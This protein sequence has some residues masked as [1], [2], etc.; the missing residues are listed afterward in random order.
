MIRRPPRSTLFPYTTLFRSI[1]RVLFKEFATQ[2]ARRSFQRFQL[3][4]S[5]RKLRV[6]S[7]TNSSH[8][9]SADLW[10]SSMKSQRQP[11]S[12][13]AGFLFISCLLGTVIS[14]QSL[15]PSRV[16]DLS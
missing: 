5:R 7:L 8:A 11:V 10:R 15:P 3:E 14:A 13:V 16:L 4:E 12:R 6:Y 1:S 2:M 9:C